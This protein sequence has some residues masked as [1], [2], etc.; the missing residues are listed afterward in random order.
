M[1]THERTSP[2]VILILFLTLHVVLIDRMVGNFLGPFLIEGLKLQHDQIG[3]IAGATGVCWALSALV[4]GAVSD[5]IGRRAVLI[6]AVFLFSLASWLSGL[7]QNF[8]QLLLTR[9]LL[10]LAEGPCFAVIMALVEECSAST[11]RARN[12]GMVN[13]AGPLAAGVAPIFATQ[14]AV[15]LGWRWG[16]YAAAVPGL[17]MGA[18]IF[19]YIKEPVRPQRLAGVVGVKV[20]GLASLLS[21][22]SLWLCLLGAFGFVTSLMAFVVFAPLYLTH[23]MQQ[24]SRT[25]GFLLGAVGFGGAAWSFFGTGIADRIGRK[26]ALMIFSVLNVASILIFMVPG[27]YATPYLLAALGF[28]LAAGPASAALIFVLIP[29][30]VV[31]RHHVAAAIGFAGIGAELLGGSLGPAVGGMLAQSHGLSAP[32]LLAAGGGCVVLMVGLL[33]RE[34]LV[35]PGTSAPGRPPVHRDGVALKEQR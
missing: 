19:L 15:A 4:F 21:N 18:L 7:A 13:S 28:A 34:T 30:E 11:H 27:L 29:A 33:I 8:E 35:R 12:V 31:P 16:F 17:V 2:W 3:L 14:I 6:P 25:A 23:V 9:S 10:G 5:R 32:M 24:E 1:T 20:Q 22:G 26:P